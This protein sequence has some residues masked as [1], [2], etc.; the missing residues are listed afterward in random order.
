VLI[1]C[2]STGEIEACR[3]EA[4]RRISEDAWNSGFQ[5]G[6]EMQQDKVDL[7]R[8]ALR[9]SA[10]RKRGPQKLEIDALLEKTG[11]WCSLCGSS[12]VE[13]EPV[14]DTCRVLR[15]R[16]RTEDGGSRSI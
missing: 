8:E 9:D 12:V 15:E 13:G 10:K 14:C 16:R 3:C 5:A 7:L 6:K 1:K 11:G 2:D 4:D